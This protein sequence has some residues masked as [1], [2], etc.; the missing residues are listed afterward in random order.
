[1]SLY[2]AKGRFPHKLFRLLSIFARL[3]G[4][5]T[6]DGSGAVSMD[7]FKILVK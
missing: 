3:R 4:L 7:I 5:E 2:F 1:M 6:Q